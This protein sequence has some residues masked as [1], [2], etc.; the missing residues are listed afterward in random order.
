MHPGWQPNYNGGVG[1]G[2]AFKRSRMPYKLIF[3]LGWDLA[4]SQPLNA[5]M[6]PE[7]RWVPSEKKVIFELG[8]TWRWVKAQVGVLWV[9]TTPTRQSRRRAPARARLPLTVY[10]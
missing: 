4:K 8:G 2:M 5:G 1:M 6:R 7:A 10:E 9:A 3:R